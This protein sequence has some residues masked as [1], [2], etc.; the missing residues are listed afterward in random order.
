MF[1]VACQRPF[2]ADKTGGMTL[3]TGERGANALTI[4]RIPKEENMFRSMGV[5]TIALTTLVA[6]TCALPSRSW[7]TRLSTRPS[8]R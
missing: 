1:D 8:T 5:W 2:P 7:P 4:T 3:Q 6:L